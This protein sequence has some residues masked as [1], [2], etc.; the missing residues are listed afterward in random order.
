MEIYIVK[1]GD[2]VFSIAEKYSVSVE[3]IISD[4]GLVNPQNL[5][6]GQSLLILI[7]KLVHTVIQGETLTSIA[8]FYNTTPLELYQNNPYL[9]LENELSV[10]Q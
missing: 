9:T 4:N 8:D 5:V 6:V 1:Q 10:G 3:R 2:T 7:P